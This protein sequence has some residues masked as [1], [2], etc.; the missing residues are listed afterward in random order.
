MATVKKRVNVTLSKELEQAIAE[1]AKREHIS[2]SRKA[3]QLLERALEI[4]EDELWDAIAK[5]RDT[6]ETKF[7]SHDDVWA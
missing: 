7:V 4:E 2:Q 5:N 3:A 1:L 6:K